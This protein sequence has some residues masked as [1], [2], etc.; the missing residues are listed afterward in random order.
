MNSGACRHALHIQKSLKAPEGEPFVSRI[1][2]MFHWILI[3]IL[4][5]LLTPAPATADLKSAAAACRRGD[6]ESALPELTR[7]AQKGNAT[8]QRMLADMYEGGAGLPRDY[9]AA[10]TWYLLAARKGDVRA[11][12]MVAQM[13]Y[14]G[15]GGPRDPQAAF[16]WYRTAAEKGHIYAQ[17]NL[18][19]L[20]EA[21]CGVTMNKVE[22]FTWYLKAARNGL[23]ESQH[24]VGRLYFTGE[25]V[26]RDL[27]KAYYWLTLSADGGNGEALT[28]RNSLADGMHP[29]ELLRIRTLAEKM[30]RKTRR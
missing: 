5:I 11:Q 13:Y 19:A 2:F 1:H 28:D 24:K 17:H 26:D 22:A 27:V 7:L 10:F 4:G 30:G 8:A 15:K 23:P 9:A 3:L 29:D 12:F 21:G 18:G 25:G 20:Y 14:E 16:Q 6:Y